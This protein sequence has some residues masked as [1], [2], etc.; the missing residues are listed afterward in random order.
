MQAQP[1]PPR[2]F[3]LLEDAAVLF[4]PHGVVAH[5]DHGDG[6][7]RKTEAMYRRYVI[8]DESMLREGGQPG[9]TPR[10]TA[11]ALRVAK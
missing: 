4:A 10:G 1:L 9:G 3:D 11:R 5:R 6:P 7:P 2:G 8:A